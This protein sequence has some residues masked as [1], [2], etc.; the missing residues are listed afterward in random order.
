MSGFPETQHPE[1]K[2]PEMQPSEGIGVGCPRNQIPQNANIQNSTP[3]RPWCRDSPK[4]NPQNANTQNTTRKIQPAEGISIG[5]P[6]IATPQQKIPKMQ[7][8][9]GICAWI[10]RNAA[11][12]KQIHKMQ[13]S[14][15]GIPE[16]QPLESKYPKCIP[17]KSLLS[18]FPEM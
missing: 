11:P 1:C 12:R 6:R 8:Q 2:I 15:S 5:I 7:P 9:E 4:R 3:R 18:V 14:V 13:Q 16:T 10:P 17:Q